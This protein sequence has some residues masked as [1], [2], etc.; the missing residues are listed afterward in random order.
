MFLAKLNLISATQ[1]YFVKLHYFKIVAD[2][3]FHHV[4][5]LSVVAMINVDRPLIMLIVYITVIIVLLLLFL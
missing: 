4:V 2:L 3:K 1:I 5:F